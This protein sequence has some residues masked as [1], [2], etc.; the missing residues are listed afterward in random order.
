M[1]SS[2]LT[3]GGFQKRLSTKP[4]ADQGVHE[5]GGTPQ[6]TLLDLSSQCFI[7]ANLSNDYG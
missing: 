4:G 7:N 6:Q 5:S 1:S 3:A 2:S